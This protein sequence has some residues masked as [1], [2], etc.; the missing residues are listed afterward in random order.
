MRRTLL[1]EK[2]NRVRDSPSHDDAASQQPRAFLQC[3]F[4]LAIDERHQWQPASR[5]LGCI[6]CRCSKKQ[7]SGLIVHVLVMDI[8]VDHLSLSGPSI[9]TARTCSTCPARKTVTGLSL[10]ATGF[11]CAAP[12]RAG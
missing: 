10:T 2:C 12:D 11:G 7:R 9:P 5:D 8:H 6:R 4:C 1:A 3:S